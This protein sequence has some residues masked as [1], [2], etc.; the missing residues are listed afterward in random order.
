MSV[1]MHRDETDYRGGGCFDELYRREFPKLLRIATALCGRRD[2]GE[3]L[4]QDAMMKVLA[5]WSTVREYDQPEAYCRRV[6]INGS[7]G[8]RR[9]Q[10]LEKRALA[11]DGA[12]QVDTLP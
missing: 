7:I 5:R 10:R 6:L 9:R 4:V 2:L 3:E 8:M 1:I 12:G 11:R